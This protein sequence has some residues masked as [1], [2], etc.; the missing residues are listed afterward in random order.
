MAFYAT[1]FSVRPAVFDLQTIILGPEAIRNKLDDI[2]TR[3]ASYVTKKDVKQKE[4]DLIII[5]ELALEMYARGFSFK[6]I[7]LTKS[8]ARKFIIDDKSLIPPFTALDGLGEQAAQSIV[9]ARKISPFVSKADL[10]TR[11]KISKTTM[12]VFNEMGITTSLD[13][14]NQLT[15]FS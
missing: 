10:L 1:Y 12:A 15:L 5:Y 8:E 7:S 4:K 2:R 3:L 6:N 13:E 11:S 9:D 14:D